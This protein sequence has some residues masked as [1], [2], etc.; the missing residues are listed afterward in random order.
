MER[1]PIFRTT[2]N[3]VKMAV[4]PKLIYRFSA[5]PTKA[6]GGFFVQGDRLIPKCIW[7]FKKRRIARTG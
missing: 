1:H 7:E 5:I 4:L 2:L 6:P 3:F